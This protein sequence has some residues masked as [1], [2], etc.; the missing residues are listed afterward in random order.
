MDKDNQAVEANAQAAATEEPKGVETDKAEQETAPQQ[1]PAEENK[2]AENHDDGEIDYKA[3]LAKV[4]AERDNYKTGLINLKKDKK[5]KKNEE[6]D[7]VEEVEEVGEDPASP[8]YL[9]KLVS[10]KVSKIVGRLQGDML[11]DQIAEQVTKLTDNPDKQKLILHHYNNSIVKSGFSKNA[12]A[13][14][15][16]I[17]MAIVDRKRIL[18]EKNELA[19]ALKA[20]NSTG[21]SAVKGANQDRKDPDPEIQLSAA[22]KVI[23]EKRAQANGMTFKEYLRKNKDK[24]IS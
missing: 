1:A 14:D 5:G 22:D 10:E 17:A 11:A 4:T 12:I 21:A 3:E 6:P 15:L 9:D 2:Q 18:R 24:L 13:G 20:K 23:L 16:E 19:E 8:D 7:E